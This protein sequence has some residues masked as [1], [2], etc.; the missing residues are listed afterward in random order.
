M[1]KSCVLCCELISLLVK[2]LNFEEDR[3]YNHEDVCAICEDC[4]IGVKFVMPTI[5][6]VCRASTS[7]EIKN[8]MN[9]DW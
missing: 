7:V 1:C 8:K 9:R 5:T 3:V 4:E 2:F 6:N